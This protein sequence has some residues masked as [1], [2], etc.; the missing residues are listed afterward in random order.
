[1]K[2]FFDG[3]PAR[4]SWRQCST[5]APGMQAYGTSCCRCQTGICGVRIYLRDCH[6]V[7]S[8]SRAPRYSPDLWVLTGRHAIVPGRY[9]VDWSSLMAVGSLSLA[10][11]F[12]LFFCS[13]RSGKRDDAGPEAN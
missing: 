13:S 12:V 10:P 2:G 5:G 1:M 6:L 4:L 8:Y 3:I 7:G 11:V 9:L